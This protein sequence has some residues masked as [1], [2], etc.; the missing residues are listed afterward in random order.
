MTG[1]AELIIAIA[2]WI[3]QQERIRL[4]ERTKAALEKAPEEG[5]VGIRPYTT[6]CTIRIIRQPGVS[7]LN[8]LDFAARFERAP[9]RDFVTE[10]P[11]LIVQETPKSTPSSQKTKSNVTGETY[12]R[13][14]KNRAGSA[15]AGHAYFSQFSGLWH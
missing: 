8:H 15:R 4:S 3:A 9:R 5:R 6:T 10:S 11:K 1:P 13:T 14:N 7:L 12:G 2:A